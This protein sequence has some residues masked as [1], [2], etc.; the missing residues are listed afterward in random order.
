MKKLF[1]FLLGIP[2]FL[3]ALLGIVLTQ[4]DP[5]QYKS[6]MAE[7]VAEHTPYQLSLG[8]VSWSF[9]PWIGVAIEDGHL[10]TENPAETLPAEA[11]I[12]VNSLEVQLRLL[13]LFKGQVEVGRVTLVAPQIQYHINEQGQDNWRL[14]ELSAADS[15]KSETNT[16]ATSASALPALFLETL[17]ISDGQLSFKDA[18]QVKDSGATTHWRIQDLNVSLSELRWAETSPASLAFQAT[19]LDTSD[20]PVMSVQ[21]M[22]KSGLLLNPIAQQFALQD[23]NL[24]INAPKSPFIDQPVAAEI[25]LKFV[26]AD[27]VADTLNASGLTISTSDFNIK[28]NATVQNL[29]NTPTINSQVSVP[30]FNLSQWLQTQLNLDLGLPAGALNKF[31]AQITLNATPETILLSPL[32]LTFD[33]STLSGEVQVSDL[34]TQ[35]MKSTLT[36]DHINLDQYLQETP[37]DSDST[38]SNVSSEASETLPPESE[39]L[40]PVLALAGLNQTSQLSIGKVT[41]QGI[42]TQNITANWQAKDGLVELTQFSADSLEGKVSANATLDVRGD[43]PKIR[44]HKSIEK[45]KVDP[46]VQSLLEKDLVGGLVTFAGDFTT[47]GNSIEEWTKAL[48]GQAK[49]DVNDGLL[50]GINLTEIVHSQLATLN[51]IIQLLIPEDATDKL[52]P[53]FQKDTHIVNLLSS[54]T[55]DQGVVQTNDLSANLEGAQVSGSGQWA[56]TDNS[57]AFELNLQLSESLSNPYVAQLQW[58]LA[59]K[60]AAEQA[61]DCSVNLEPVQTTLQQ[62]AEDK[63]Q[64][65]VKALVNQKANE[66]LGLEGGAAPEDALKA[67]LSDEEDAAKAQ[68]REKEEALKKQAEDKLKD[69]LNRLF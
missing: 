69:S 26:Q 33:Q 61:I 17:S 6:L 59:C 63:A 34:A 8:H 64:A 14:S 9:F 5:N 31:G 54:L 50:K 68:L 40:I 60:V 32:E 4:V 36:L 55:I 11:L 19:Q 45:A 21:V 58:P 47:E 49:L 57:G 1:W 62:M 10:T 18:S 30:T 12:S 15:E 2:V 28:G 53:T 51:P 37:T 25:A 22:A 56:L 38:P 42:E 13:P 16:A 67:K 39:P 44:V 23:L 43:T 65:K 66:A 41:Y 3:I 48:S 7:Q 20:N 27:L 46:L 52:P 29:T 35:A 24:S